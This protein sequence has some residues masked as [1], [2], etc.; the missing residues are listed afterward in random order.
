MSTL[1]NALRSAAREN[2][3]VLGNAIEPLAACAYE[4]ELLVKRAG[5]RKFVESLRCKDLRE[6]PLIPSPLSRHYRTTTRRRMWFEKNRAFLVHG[7]GSGRNVSSLLEPREHTE[8]YQQAQ[9]LI[10]TMPKGLVELINHVVIRGTYTEHALII[11][12][13][14]MSANVV[15]AL[16]LFAKHICAE[17]PSVLHVWVYVDPR[18]SRFYLDLDRPSSGITS[19]KL[20]GSAAYKHE[21]LG[22]QFQVGVFSFSQINQAVLPSFVEAVMQSANVENTDTL[23]DL[24]CGYGLFG[25]IAAKHVKSVVAVDADVSTVDNARYN[26]RRAGGTVMAVAEHLTQSNMKNIVRSVVGKLRLPETPGQP[27]NVVA[28][29]DPP[30]TGSAPGVI[31]QLAVLAPKRVV[32]VHCGP[33]EIPR[34]IKEWKY[35]GYA[36]TT[37][38]AFDL[39]PGTL[40]L[41][42]VVVFEPVGNSA[43][44]DDV[45]APSRKPRYTSRQPRR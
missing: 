24:Y 11:N 7:D 26:I 31:A 12:V 8:I 41:E 17:H 9:E 38:Q 13:R 19:K 33:D 1:E 5:F 16:R 34:T 32:M 27:R 42:V 3:V 45:P 4:Q 30:R 2:N 40:Q 10:D 37:I 43:T 15:R 44:K 35:A 21:L 6:L 39:F 36:P 22:E 14:T 29:V 18:G 23:I 28:I 20:L 25:G